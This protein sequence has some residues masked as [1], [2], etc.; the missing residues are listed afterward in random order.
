MGAINM[1]VCQWCGKEY[2]KQHNRQEY[3]STHCREQ[4]NLEKARIRQENYRKR[5]KVTRC[6]QTRGLGSNAAS[7][8]PHPHEN[9]RTELNLVEK[10]LQNLK[11]R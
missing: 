8:G 6:Q 5:W 1:S 10:Q 9:F 2:E 7:L 4:G 11:L 3:C